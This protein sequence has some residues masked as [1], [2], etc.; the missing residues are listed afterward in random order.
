[1]T[2]PHEETLRR[3]AIGERSLLDA[4]LVPDH[5]VEDPVISAKVAALVRIGAMV[6]L[7]ASTSCYQR[8]VASAMAAGATSEEIVHALMTV[9]PEAG[10]VRVVAA[11]PRLALAI[12]YDVETAIETLG[13]LEDPEA[14]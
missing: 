14:A 7:D 1:M 9:A 10:V 5:H 4:I 11:A 13:P 2:Q 12:G 3:L 8:A 6:A